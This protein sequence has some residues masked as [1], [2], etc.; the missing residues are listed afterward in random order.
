MQILIE[1]LPIALFF[2]AYQWAGIYV[3]TGVAILASVAHLLYG[4]YRK[5]HFEKMP[6]ITLITISVLGGATLIFRNELFIKLKP[7]V[8]YWVLALVF[9]GSRWIGEQP[10]LQR[11]MGAQIQMPARIWQQLNG[12]WALFF[13]LMGA[14]NLY[15]VHHFDTPTWVQFKLF[16]SL[17]LTLIFMIGQGFYMSKYMSKHHE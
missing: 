11:L 9:V 1:F 12:S 5:G 4:R 6:L 2:L 13:G 3:A 8:L 15:V 16:G 17:G 14:L 7:T 10:L